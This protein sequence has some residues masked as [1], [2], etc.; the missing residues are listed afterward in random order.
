M[1]DNKKSGTP[2]ISGRYPDSLLLILVNGVTYPPD[3]RED[4]TS[5]DFRSVKG[6]LRQGVLFLNIT[7]DPTNLLRY[8]IPLTGGSSGKFPDN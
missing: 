4:L 2:F 7:S 6:F 5:S 3:L 1:A 8:H